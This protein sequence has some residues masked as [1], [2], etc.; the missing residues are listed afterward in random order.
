MGYRKG[1]LSLCHETSVKIPPTCAMHRKE[2]KQ[3]AA[4]S[5]PGTPGPH[6]QARRNKPVRVTEGATMVLRREGKARGKQCADFWGLP[7]GMDDSV[8]QCHHFRIGGQKTVNNTQG[9]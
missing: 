9:A 3:Q 4:V 8:I 7:E 6:G 1:R 5:W 2:A